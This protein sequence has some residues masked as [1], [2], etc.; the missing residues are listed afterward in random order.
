MLPVSGM[1]DTREGAGAGAGTGA[2][3]GAGARYYGAEM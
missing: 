2:G 3:A 1:R